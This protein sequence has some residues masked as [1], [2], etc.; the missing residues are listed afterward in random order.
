[1]PAAREKVGKDLFFRWEKRML[2]R[3]R[4]NGKIVVNSTEVQ[5]ITPSPYMKLEA[6][7]ET[8]SPVLQS[9]NPLSSLR[10]GYSVTN[11]NMH[12]SPQA[13][14]NPS[15]HM[16]SMPQSWWIRAEWYA[17]LLSPGFSPQLSGGFREK[18]SVF[19]L[20]VGWR[21]QGMKHRVPFPSL[22]LGDK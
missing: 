3:V 12:G 8:R 7:W 10:G 13:T 22:S 15:Q 1:M 17:S 19:A 6:E 21:K 5:G 20:R 11:C 18:T 4:W 2:V 16:I 14:K 9:G